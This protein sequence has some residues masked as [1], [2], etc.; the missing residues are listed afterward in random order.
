M[1]IKITERDEA[2]LLFKKITEVF[3]ISKPE[4]LEKKVSR[5]GKILITYF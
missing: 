3:R 1:F 4:D 5:S 2:Q